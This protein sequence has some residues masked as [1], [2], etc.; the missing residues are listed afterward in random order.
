MF[1]TDQFKFMIH[2]RISDATNILKIEYYPLPKAYYE[3]G[4]CLFCYTVAFEIEKNIS[5]LKLLEIFITGMSELEGKFKDE[6]L[7]L[8]PFLDDFPPH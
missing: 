6:Y 4:G 5:N 2:P 3:G 7:R 1:A 8:I